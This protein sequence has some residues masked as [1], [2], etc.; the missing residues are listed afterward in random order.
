MKTR[1]IPLALALALSLFTALTAYGAG[2]ITITVTQVD[3]S[4]FPQIEVY[5]SVTDAAGNPVRNLP[6]GAFQLQENGQT[7][8]MTAATRAGEQ[9]PVNSVLVIDHSGSMRL[10]GKMDGARQAASAFV[11]LMRAGDRTALIQFDT[12]IDVLQPLTDDKNALLTSIQK[13]VPRGNTAIYDALA[14]SDKI[15]QPITGRKAVILL[16]DGLDNSSQVPRDAILKEASG[17]GLS[18][19]TLGVGNKATGAR[20]EDGVD[21][22]V[23]QSLAGASNGTYAYAP[24]ASLL[25]DLY[26]Q[27]SARIQN[28]Y[29]LTYI[30]PNALH[31]GVR[32]NIVVTAPS[33]ADTRVTYNPGGVIPEVASQAATSSWPLFALALFALLA[34]LFAPAGVTLARQRAFARKPGSRVKW[35]GAAPAPANATTDMP[36]A[37]AAA[38]SRPIRIQAG[39]KTPATATGATRRQLPWD[40]DVTKH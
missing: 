3:T 32:R 7:L 25:T 16:T 24:E 18:I 30:S 1:L 10:A 17:S 29:K 11:N 13:I 28:E 35:T 21:E 39:K 20:G 4:R 12:A 8:N 9:G 23:L 34:L 31:D 6:A 14:Q 5:V 26:Q 19:Y 37:S 40:E 22:P 27:L 15:L 36:K 2:P 38:S 33:A